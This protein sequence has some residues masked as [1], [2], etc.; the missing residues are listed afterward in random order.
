L[1][2]ANSPVFPGDF[3]QQDLDV[4]AG[5]AQWFQVLND[6]AMEVAPCRQ[7]TSSECIDGDVRVHLRRGLLRRTGESMGFVNHQTDI[8]VA[9]RNLEGVAQGAVNGFHDGHFFFLA[10]VPSHFDKFQHA[11]LQARVDAAFEN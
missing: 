9:G 5:N 6:A 1:P 4:V 8:S 7:R 2:A 11:P 10:V 3:S